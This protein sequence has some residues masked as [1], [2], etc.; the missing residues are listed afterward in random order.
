MY[1][2]RV[3]HWDTCFPYSSN[4][5]FGTWPCVQA[6]GQGNPPFLAK[7]LCKNSFRAIPSSI[8]SHPKS[9]MCYIMILNQHQH[10]KQDLHNIHTSNIHI[11]K[12][13]ILTHN[14]KPKTE[15]DH[16]RTRNPTIPTSHSSLLYISNTTQHKTP[17]LYTHRVPI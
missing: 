14:F 15:L 8:T 16:A 9:P 1:P 5:R 2:S 10:I 11:H 6:M 12:Q 7:I 17:L 3:S 4:I 13:N